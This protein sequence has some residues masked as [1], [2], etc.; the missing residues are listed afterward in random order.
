MWWRVGS[1]YHWFLV[2]LPEPRTN[3]EK[4]VPVLFLCKKQVTGIEFAERIL[5]CSLIVGQ[6]VYLPKGSTEI[7]MFSQS[8]KSIAKSKHSLS[9][10]NC[11]L[12]SFVVAMVLWLLCRMALTLNSGHNQT[13]W[14]ILGCFIICSSHKLQFLRMK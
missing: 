11:L 13:L 12:Q 6:Q 1:R 4:S 10:S 7:A 3:C 5:C 8:Q 9:S 2:K 14:H